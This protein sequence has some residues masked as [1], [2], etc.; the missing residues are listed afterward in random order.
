MLQSLKALPKF[1]QHQQTHPV[2]IPNTCSLCLLLPQEERILC[3]KS[4]FCKHASLKGKW[5]PG[6]R[7]GCMWVL[8]YTAHSAD[9]SAGMSSWSLAGPHCFAFSET[10]QETDFQACPCSW[11]HQLRL[12]PGRARN[13]CCLQRK[14]IVYWRN[15]QVC[16]SEKYQWTSL[17]I[18]RQLISY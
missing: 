11:S 5:E 6:A 4:I 1:I 2:P 12:L 13:F 15:L 9:R 17:G 7:T 8:P 18:Q 14:L 16:S 3:C 10:I